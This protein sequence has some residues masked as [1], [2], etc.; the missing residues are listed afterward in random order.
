MEISTTPCNAE[1]N[2][3]VA[4]A[5]FG[6]TTHYS[7][8]NVITDQRDPLYAHKATSDPDTFYLREAMKTKIGPNF[9][10]LCKRN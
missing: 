8:Q 7:D 1:H 10:L 2:N 3:H 4:G 5:I 6:Y 9:N